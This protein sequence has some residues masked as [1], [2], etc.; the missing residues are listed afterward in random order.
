MEIETVGVESAEEE[1][2]VSGAGAG[3]TITVARDELVEKLGVVGRA[4]STRGTVQVLSGIL[5]AAEG[6]AITLAATDME[7]SLR[8][9]LD[10]QVDGDGAVVIPGKPLVELAR[11]LPERDVTLQYR[12]EEGTVQIT[13]GSYTSRLHVFNAEDFP[14]LPAVDA[15]LHA[16][17]RESLLDTIGRVA[18]SASRDESRPVLTGILVRFEAGKL[19]MVATDSYRLSV[20]ETTLGEAAPELEAIIPARA[21]TELARLAGGDSVELGVHENHVVFGTGAAWLTTRR[22]DGQFPNYKQLLPEVF[23]VELTLPKAELAD[24]V[25][26]ASVLALRNSPLRLRLAEGELTVSAQTQDVG[27][28]QETMPAAYSGEEFVIGFNAEFLRDGV[29]SIVGDDLF[30][31][32]INPLRPAILQDTAGDFTYLIMPI[33][34]AG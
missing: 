5:L 1:G 27:E 17:E 7:L 2:T 32:L 30:L 15:Q 24:V 21:L 20:K 9:A 22:I 25:R 16:I 13:S 33:R 19:V 26:R 6:G 8:T 10:A 34:L 4:V 14:R 31:K 28:T 12:P 29:D 23:E 3:M 18:R 11:L